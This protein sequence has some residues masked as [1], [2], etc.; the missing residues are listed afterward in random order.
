M[1]VSKE[2]IEMCSKAQEVQEYKKGLFCELCLDIKLCGNFFWD[3]YWEE[4]MMSNC[5]FCK[6]N[7]TFTR[8]DNFHKDIKITNP[9]DVLIW[10][11]RIDQLKEIYGENFGGIL[12]KLL[13]PIQDDYASYYSKFGWNN[14]EQMLLA[15]IMKE[16]HNKQWNRETREWE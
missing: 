13:S 5:G 14:F 16:K 9:I 15:F 12:S 4:I 6:N 10:L 7:L 1:D 2:Y 3:R 11:P 8:F